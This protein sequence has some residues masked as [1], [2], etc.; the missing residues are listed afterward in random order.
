MLITLNSLFTGIPH[1]PGK[2]TSQGQAHH[3]RTLPHADLPFQAI[4][5]GEEEEEYDSDD[6]VSGTSSTSDEDEAT[7]IALAKSSYRGRE[8]A[9]QR[10]GDGGRQRGRC[11]ASVPMTSFDPTA[12]CYVQAFSHF[13]HRYTRRTMLVCDLQGVLSVDEG[14][15][16]EGC[17]GMF[18]LTDPVIHYKSRSGRKQV[19]GRTDFGMQ[20]MHRFF[21][22]H[23]CNDVC[24]L[25]GLASQTRR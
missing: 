4:P 2:Y 16:K 1:L 24:V 11:P 5:E 21:E 3:A 19:Y 7:L 12:E 17:E 18:E 9:G 10:G 20:G 23:L 14:S 25:L 8:M 13:S 22:T 15:K 6:V